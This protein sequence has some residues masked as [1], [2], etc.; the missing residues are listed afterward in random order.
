[1]PHTDVRVTC[2]AQATRNAL[3]QAAA[4]QPQFA[5]GEAGQWAKGLKMDAAR[6]EQIALDVAPKGI[7]PKKKK[8]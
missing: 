1:M 8:K 6:A 5:E 7:T 4:Q 3:H 2:D